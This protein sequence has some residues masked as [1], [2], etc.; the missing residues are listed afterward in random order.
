MADSNPVAEAEA[1]VAKAE[2][3]LAAAKAEPTTEE[4]LAN[5]PPLVL[6]Q[7]TK[8]IKTCGHCGLNLEEPAP[9]IDCPNCGNP[10][11]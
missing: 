5:A 9:G 3:D 2:A 6:P 10:L 1:E 4:L 7:G 8:L 11:P